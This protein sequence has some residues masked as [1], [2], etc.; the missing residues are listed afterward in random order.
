MK[1]I[2]LFLLAGALALSALAGC[3]NTAPSNSSQA[4][5][6]PSEAPSV[7]EAAPAES[8]TPVELTVVTTYGGDDGNRINYE[9]A[10]KAYEQASGNKIKDASGTAVEEWKAK[11]LA[12]FGTGAEPDV[13]FYFNG[14]DSNP[15]VSA[16]KVVSVDEIRTVYPEYASNM[17][18]EMLG[19]SPTDQKNYSVPV[20]GYWEGLFVNK[21]VLEAAGVAVPGPDYTWEQFLADCQKILDAGY[22]PIAASLQEVPHYWFEFCILNHGTV[23]THGTLPASSTDT[24]G[25]AWVAGLNDMK[26]L[27][28]SGFFPT[29]TLTATDAETFQ[30]MAD[31][32]AAFA[33]D[34]S[35]KLGW[36]DENAADIND[37]T[38]VYPPAQ[39]DRKT[40]DIVGGLSSGYYI[41][42]KAWDDPAKQAAAVSFVE[43]MTTDSVVNAFGATAITALKNGTTPPADATTLVESALALTKGAT[44][45]TPATQ[46]GLNQTAR[47]ALFA[48]I[49]NIVTGTTTPEAAIDNALAINSQN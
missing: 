17:K 27:Y 7:S 18:D 38:V 36:F 37:F 42:R 43:A 3:T 20:N 23:A 34:G 21:K 44:G 4:S 11:V 10:Y 25:Q 2:S 22:V 39:G 12:D 40:T 24:A 16:G 1:R 13:L 47:T 30:L 6:A 45:I 26:T 49:K 19:A 41:T 14:V 48:D 28:E 33:I 32:K 5:A 35:W 29:N 31:N 46:D 8:T 15:F 9:N